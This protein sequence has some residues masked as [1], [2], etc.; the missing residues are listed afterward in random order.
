MIY[1]ARLLSTQELNIIVLTKRALIPRSNE[2]C[3]VIGVN[4]T[5][6]LA[7]SFC[8]AEQTLLLLFWKRRKTF[9]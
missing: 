1:I 8:E 9:Y 4:G 3:R 7:W 6:I 5:V 2:V